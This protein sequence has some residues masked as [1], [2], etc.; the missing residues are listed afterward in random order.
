LAII[1]GGL[2]DPDGAAG[3]LADLGDHEPWI[4]D[5]LQV[6]AVRALAPSTDPGA[7]ASTVAET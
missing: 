4:M 3:T 7:P 5:C 1:R 6:L 2:H